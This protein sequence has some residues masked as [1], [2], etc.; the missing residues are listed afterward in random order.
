MCALS[1][2]YSRVA[3]CS[4][5]QYVAKLLFA[6]I[7][8]LLITRLMFLNI[9]FMFVFLFCV[10]VFYFA[11]SVFLYFF[12]YFSSFAYCCLIPNFVTVYRLLPP[13]GNLFVVNI[14]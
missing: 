9:L 13:G 1:L 12:V 14:I 11:H 10:F 8:Y 6:S 4:S 2:I 7:C 3:V 5:V